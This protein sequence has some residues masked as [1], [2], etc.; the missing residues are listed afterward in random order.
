MAESMAFKLSILARQKR[1]PILPGQHDG[2]SYGIIWDACAIPAGGSCYVVTFGDEAQVSIIA[3]VDDRGGVYLVDHPITMAPDIRPDF[4]AVPDAQGGSGTLFVKDRSAILQP[5]GRYSGSFGGTMRELPHTQNEVTWNT[6]RSLTYRPFM[7]SMFLRYCVFDQGPAGWRMGFS[8]ID[9]NCSNPVRPIELF[10]GFETATLPD[11]VDALIYRI[12][13]MDNPSGI[14]SFARRLMGEADP[15]RLRRTATRTKLSLAYIKHM[16]GFYINVD[17]SHDVSAADLAFIYGFEA[18]LNRL[19]R[20][21]A[22]LGF[23]MR[24]ATSS[25]SEESCCEFDQRILCGVTSNVARIMACVNDENEWAMPGTI[26][27]QA[28]GE[29]DVRTRFARIAEAIN[30]IVRLEYD[31]RV[32]VSQ[33]IIVVR[34]VAPTEEAMPHSLFDARLGGWRRIHKA[35]REDYAREYAARI[36]LVLASIAFASG[37][38]ITSCAIMQKN[39]LNHSL[40]QTYVFERAA[41]LADAVPFA[42]ARVGATLGDDVTAVWLKPYEALED[43]AIG[44]LQNAAHEHA[45]QNLRNDARLLPAELS[46]LLQ[47]DTAQELEIQ[48][49]KESSSWQRYLDLRNML[50]VDPGRAMDQMVQFIGE[51]EARCAAEELLSDRPA[52]SYFCENYLGRFL[53]PLLEQ[54]GSTHILRAPDALYF[55]LMELVET[56]TRNGALNAALPEA[57]KLL[58]LAPTSMQAHFMLINILATLNLFDDVIQ[59]AIHGLSVCY[60]RDAIVYLL[61]R[62]AYA[63]WRKGNREVALACYTLV[64]DGGQISAIAYDEKQALMAEMG[65]SSEL[66]VSSAKDILLAADIPIPPTQEVAQQIANAAVLF[67]DNGFLYLAGRCA[68]HMWKFNG[69]DELG[70]VYRSFAPAW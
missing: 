60:E 5:C 48:E 63:F 36:V 34:F 6:E 20:L 62:M 8:N 43:E 57:R 70:V 45:T 13:R 37:L 25:P 31:F 19:A 3:Y 9:I 7:A 27:C 12:D 52:H 4:A 40:D 55:S 2:I 42:A 24:P 50:E 65:E 22:A 51:L 10:Q 16:G 23:G 26:A 68:Y 66:S 32:N 69:V 30:L 47:A 59:V 33:G 39:I 64:P 46:K 61:Y 29:W 38:D 15:A 44:M 35:E 14:E 21:L 54:D 17:R 11:A 41:F 1:L 58:A 49:D 56:L 28:G 67:A 18:A 53:L